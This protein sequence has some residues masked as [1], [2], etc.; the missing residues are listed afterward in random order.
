MSAPRDALTKILRAG[1]QKMLAAPVEQEVASYVAKRA[2]LLD[3]V[4]PV[5]RDALQFK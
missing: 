1:A 5:Q 4:G 2:G 3:E